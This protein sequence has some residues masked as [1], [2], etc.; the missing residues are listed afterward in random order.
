[1]KDFKKLLIWQLGMEIVD[2]VYGIVPMLP[3]EERYGLRSQITRSAVS[4]P[5]NIAE[6]SAKRST[7]EK[8][9]FVEISLGSAF[10]LETQM[11]AVGRRQW[12]EQKLIDEVIDNVRKEQSMISKFIEKL[13]SEL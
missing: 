6:G 10:E 4:I 12:I 5:S 3:Q 2:S 9:K 8:L 7:K 11:L 13:E 1:M